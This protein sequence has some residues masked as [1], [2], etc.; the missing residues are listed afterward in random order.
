[1]KEWIYSIIAIIL[2]TT[3]ITI[4]VPD[5]K[6]GKMIKGIFSLIV[7]LVIISPIL[8]FSSLNNEDFFSNYSVENN[9]QDTFLNFINDNKTQSIQNDIIISFEEIGVKNAIVDLDYDY[10]DDY[11]FSIK[12]AKIYLNNTVIKSNKEHILVIEELI[13]IVKSKT[14]L[15]RKDIYIYE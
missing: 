1:M 7:M 12:N 4:I 2:L 3:I 15:L 8:S 6:L 11:V 9:I 10:S 5:G 14:N 13:N